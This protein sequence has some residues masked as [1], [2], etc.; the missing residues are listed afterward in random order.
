M[1][2]ESS[3]LKNALPAHQPKW[4]E[5]LAGRTVAMMAKSLAATVRFE[6]EDP[7]RSVLQQPAI[8]CIWHNRL[9]LC[10]EIFRRYIVHHG[11]QRRSLRYQRESRWCDAL[12]RVESLRS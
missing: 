7:H 1:A 2:K 12:C 10:L 9:A 8:F 11:D 5:K 3:S 6:F 4:A